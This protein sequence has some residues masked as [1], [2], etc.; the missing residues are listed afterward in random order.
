MSREICGFIGSRALYRIEVP[1]DVF[2]RLV[3]LVRE[4]VHGLPE[5][6]DLGQSTVRSRR[7]VATAD[8]E[9]FEEQE[10]INGHHD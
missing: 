1:I 4:G 7:I 2:H 5:W 10:I 3:T 8:P 9:Y 6:I